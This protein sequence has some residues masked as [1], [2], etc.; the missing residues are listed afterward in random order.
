MGFAVSTALA[1]Q[2]EL[3]DNIKGGF[4]FRKGSAAL[5]S[6]G[7]VASTGYEIVHAT[8]SEWRPLRSG[9]EAI[10]AYLERSKRPPQALCGIELRCPRPFVPAEFGDF[11]KQYVE[12]LSNRDLLI[13][14]SNPVARVNLA[15]EIDPPSEVSIY[16]FSYAAPRNSPPPGFVLAASDQAGAYPDGIVARGDISPAGLRRKLSQVLTS[17]DNYLKALG[18]NWNQATA[19]SLYTVHD[20]GLLIPEM[21][22]PRIG[23]AARFGIHWYYSRPPV[24]EVEIEI[25]VRACSREV[26]V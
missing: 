14:G 10:D 18:V 3:T 7:V 25:G 8:F 13:N 16:G 12:L 17:L 23:R 19:V 21:L 2:P 24:P 1:D 15:P 11:N 20:L 6:G 9:F 5:S 4:R 22:A 26:M